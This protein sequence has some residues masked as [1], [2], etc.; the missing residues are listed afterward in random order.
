VDNQLSEVLRSPQIHGTTWEASRA[1]ER[2]KV[3]QWQ[4]TA[5]RNS[6]QIVAPTPPAP[7]AIF[8]VLQQSQADELALLKLSQPSNHFA[9]GYAYANAG[10]LDQA[11]SELQLVPKADANYRLAQKFLSQINR[12]RSPGELPQ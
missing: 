10:V 1:L 8:K 11:V 3:Y 4:V 6:E 9:L 7:E 2:G 5:V 12:L